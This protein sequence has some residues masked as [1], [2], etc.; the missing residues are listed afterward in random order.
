MAIQLQNFTIFQIR[1]ESECTFPT[2]IKFYQSILLTEDD[3]LAIFSVIFLQMYC[4][5]FFF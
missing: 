2:A 3:L 5:V 1:G 4:T